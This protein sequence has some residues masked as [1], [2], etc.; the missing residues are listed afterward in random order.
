LVDKKNL[1]VL[2]NDASI[3]LYF[4]SSFNKNKIDSVI[5]FNNDTNFYTFSISPEKLIKY[6][7]FKKN[8]SS[9]KKD[10]LDKYNTI[11][12]TIIENGEK[13]V[14]KTNNAETDFYF[15]LKSITGLY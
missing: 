11:N 3:T 14:I 9:L 7:D 15:L 6:I 4:N 5:N 10:T 13:Q 1:S 2:K 12:Y 8:V